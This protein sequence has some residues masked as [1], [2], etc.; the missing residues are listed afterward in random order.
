MTIGRICAL[1][2]VRGIGFE[3]FRTVLQRTEAARRLRPRARGAA[4][5]AAD[6]QVFLRA[7]HADPQRLQDD[8]LEL[9]RSVSATV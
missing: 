5:R 9:R 4:G 1:D 2:A 8:L 3:A 6:G 7:R